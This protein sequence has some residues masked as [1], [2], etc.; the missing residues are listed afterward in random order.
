MFRNGVGSFS[1]L[2]I[3]LGVVSAAFFY[4]LGMGQLIPLLFLI[5]VLWLALLAVS[6]SFPK[7][8]IYFTSVYVCFQYYPTKELQI[9]PEYFVWGDE[10][11]LFFLTLGWICNSLFQRRKF[12]RTPF[13]VPIFLII[14]VGILSGIL[15]GTDPKLAFLGIRGV[16][17]NVLVF[18]AVMNLDIDRKFAW[19][20]IYLEIALASV[21]ACPS[22]FQFLKSGVGDNVSGFFGMGQ[23]NLMGDLLMVLVF[24]PL[25]LHSRGKNF[26]M[27]LSSIIFIFFSAVA[28]GSR[29]SFYVFVLTLI[30]FYKTK[31]LFVFKYFLKAIGILTIPFLF[32]LMGNWLSK[33]NLFYWLSPTVYYQ[34]ETLV[35]RGSAR[36]L[37]YPIAMDSLFHDAANP[38][39]G[40][41]PGSYC[42]FTGF[43]YLPQTAKKIY[44]PF[45]QIELGV[46]PGVD[47]EVIS[48]GVE[49]GIIGLLCFQF[50]IWKSYRRGIRCFLSS[51]DE[52]VK[53]LGAVVGAMAIYLA[54][55]QFFRNVFEVQ[56]ISYFFWLNSALLFKMFSR[57]NSIEA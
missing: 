32:L 38:L 55:G 56:F 41:G 17:Q 39:V 12:H 33:E 31:V 57:P 37:F 34:S 35:W 27:G 54:I 8:L 14:G 19:N 42:S 43:R 30:W 46:D 11:V 18:Y 53:T 1:K 36:F 28:S 49:F 5:P 47:I 51:K 25:T 29:L 10:V 15:N 52:L 22:L 26:L 4:F 9:I 13:D 21:Q 44:N 23:A 50:L 16:L 7:V 40:L 3:V 48:I 45:R 2:L 24:L 20:L 6:V